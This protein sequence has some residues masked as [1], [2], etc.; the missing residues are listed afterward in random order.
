MRDSLRRR[1]L[2]WFTATLVVVISGFGGIVV[3]AAWCTYVI[4]VDDTLAARAD[5]LVAAIEPAGSGTFDVARPVEARASGLYPGVYHAI[6]TGTGELID[7]SDAELDAEFPAGDGFA[8][9]RGRRELAVRAAEGVVVLVGRDLAD[10]RADLWTLAGAVAAIGAAA[11]ALAVAGGW[12][13]AGRALAPI[14]RIS[15][16]ARAMVGGDLAAR[17]PIDRVETELG[18]LAQALNEAFDRL[19]ASLER[20]RR[21]T[22]DASHELR[23]PLTTL[24]TEIQWAL[25]RPRDAGDYRQSLETARRAAQRM[26]SITERLLTLARAEAP[27]VAGGQETV[28]LDDVVR[29]AVQDLAPLAAHKGITMS[30]SLEPAHVTASPDRLRD[31][32]ANVLTNAIQYN[33]DGG[34]VDVTQRRNGDRVTLSI[35]DT[36]IGIAAAHLPRVFHPFFRADPARSRDAG[37]AGLGLAVT[38][39]VVRAAGG[40]TQCVSELG[41]GTTIEIRLPTGN[42]EI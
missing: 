33:V 28:P 12:W 37:G 10:R 4:E 2:G 26:Q 8:T 21:F 24:S 5:A 27:L 36:G 15:R 3:Y 40:T 35:T 34:R 42:L 29:A 41:V 11:I 9:R 31:A 30:V 14:A 13:V 38:D 7:R 22:A 25:A 1:L 17:I 23:T 20:Q 32:I 18:Q 39:A 19:H 6:W 16:T